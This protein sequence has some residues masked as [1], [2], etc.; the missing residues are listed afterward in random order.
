MDG[1]AAP[2]RSPGADGDGK[3]AGEDAAFEIRGGGRT[4]EIDPGPLAGDHVVETLRTTGGFYE[5]DL[6]EWL[7]TLRIPPGR[8]VDAG[9]F[10]GNHTLYFAGVLGREVTAYE[11]NPVAYD[12]LTRN[13]ARNGLDALVTMRRVALGERAGRAVLVPPEGADNLGGTAIS[14]RADGDVEVVSLDGDLR[15]G[16]G[17]AVA[18]L[19]LDVEGAELA[20]L[21]G[22]SGLIDAHAPLLL[23]E[24]MTARA[25]AQAREALAE[26]AYRPVGVHAATPVFAFAR[27]DKAHGY[28]ADGRAPVFDRAYHDYRAHIERRE[29]ANAQ[30]RRASDLA[31]RQ[32]DRI[33]RATKDAAGAVGRLLTGE[34]GAVRTTI[35]SL[36]ATVKT[37][38]E[39]ARRRA[40]EAERSAAR[41][42]EAEAAARS[43]AEGAA[44][45]ARS[46]RT[47]AE[48]S[49]ARAERSEAAAAAARDEARA[50]ARDAAKAD[51][52][53]LALAADLRAVS[54]ALERARA[55]ALENNA[56]VKAY[57]QAASRLEGSAGEI[58][59]SSAFRFGLLLTS[60]V[61]QPHRLALKGARRLAGRPTP[62][63]ALPRLPAA[64]RALGVPSPASLRKT[65]RSDLPPPFVGAIRKKR[66]VGPFPVSDLRLALIADEFTRLS[67]AATCHVRDLTPQ[68]WEEALAD[69][70]VD[71]LFIESAWQGVDG[72]WHRKLQ[73]M[74]QA[75][76]DIL[77]AARA[78]GVPVLFWNKEDPIHT[79]AWLRLAGEADYVFTSDAESVPAYVAALGHERIGVFPFACAPELTDPVSDIP[80]AEGTSFAGS[81]YRRYPERAADLDMLTSLAMEH[82][83]LTIYDRNSGK[84]YADFAYPKRF[85]PYLR[86]S[87]PFERIAEAY[88][89]YQASINMNSV[90]QS[91]SMFA[92][93]A[94]ELMASGTIVLSNY[95]Y[96]MRLLLGDLALSAEDPAPL[97]ARLSA[98][99]DPSEAARLRVRALRRVLSEHTYAHRLRAAVATVGL[100]AR[101]PEPFVTV[102]AE[103]ASAA[104]ARGIAASFSR[105][106]YP[107]KRLIVRTRGDAASVARA[108]PTGAVLWAGESGGAAWRQATRA[109]AAEPGDL[110]AVFSPSVAYGPAHLTDLVLSRRY[111]AGDGATRAEEG[112]TFARVGHAVPSRSVLTTALAGTLGADRLLSDA[113]IGGA[114][115]T[116]DRFNIGPASADGDALDAASFPFEGVPITALD[117]GAARLRSASASGPQSRHALDASALARALETPDR[118]AVAREDGPRGPVLTSR[119]A[120]EKHAYAYFGTY[121]L[122]ALRQPD[123]DHLTVRLDA[124]GDL[125]LQV[126]L[127]FLTADGDRLAPVMPPPNSVRRVRVPDG[128]A[129]VRLGVRVQGPGEA[130]LTSLGFGMGAHSPLAWVPRADTLVL[131][132][133]YPS[134]DD[135]YRNGFVHRRVRTYWDEGLAC[136]VLRFDARATVRRYEFEGVDVTVGH[137][138]ELEAAL[139]SGAYADVLVHFL[140]PRM[141]AVLK[142]YLGQVRLTVWL[143][144]SDV[145]PWHR[146]EFNYA[147]EAARERAIK[148]SAPREAMWAEVLAVRH[149]MLRFVFVADYAR[150]EVEEDYGAQIPEAQRTVVHNFIDTD[151]FAYH[152]KPPEQRFEVLS[153]R[154]FASAKYAND[155]T[156]AAILALSEREGFGDYRFRLFGDGVLFEE[157]VAPLRHLEN[158][159]I[160][161]GFLTQPEIAALHRAYGV[162]LSPTRMD[163]QGVSRDEAMS[164]GLVPVTTD[165]TAIPEF[166]DEDCGF[167]CPPDDPEAV[168][169]AIERIAREPELFARLSA[170]A[171][172]RVRAQS[173]F[174]QTIAREIDLVRAGR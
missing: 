15:G 87:L 65:D 144:G 67:L 4:F 7:S 89:G 151:L 69:F 61:R 140:E 122:D 74:P 38:V 121:D 66:R 72:C 45:A 59:G 164:S 30:L 48:R 135:I 174:A 97:R 79:K 116:I 25:F 104:E 68:G 6:L 139:A 133:T 165:C 102:L 126:V 142:P 134:Y 13:V 156:V 55:D 93:R 173:G 47:E 113:P 154:P 51:R 160:T 120:P 14:A 123:A 109:Q 53:S 172:A 41:S 130:I 147:D 99:E 54:D 12:M 108:L 2:A 141:W 155:V 107:S 29:D 46:S 111:H 37:A 28:F 9:A 119:L 106:A 27:E 62:G 86:D 166:V 24:C 1:E 146:R 168:A 57:R 56:R 169:D 125:A 42:A 80:R 85:A 127:A 40:E 148:L 159:E 91:S 64:P 60:A 153:I 70:E 20:A 136:D 117:A 63:P 110:V 8:V 145:Q 82:G 21:T 33:D 36:D 162:W 150:R 118:A 81:Y 94:F 96:G 23:V 171:A 26:S 78:A 167:L 10:V 84:G 128:A 77:E 17:E 75:L 161:Q 115:L 31:A 49:D 152:A 124:E 143:H 170:A 22:A 138:A 18:L 137:E 16:D 44:R 32:D 90:R 19:K 76:L 5:R 129:R 100:D 3:G 112:G 149:P 88:K 131:A 83:P 158:V 43:D 103:A 98:L 71:V 132:Q 35:T 114:F 11:P 157:T 92:R 105:Q 95:S 101:L 73:K 58:A 39:D 34:I 163:W 52:R 50:S